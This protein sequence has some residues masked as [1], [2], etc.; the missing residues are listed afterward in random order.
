MN[1][2]TWWRRKKNICNEKEVSI[3]ISKKAAAGVG[4]GASSAEKGPAMVR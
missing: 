1:C 2:R 3:M 4:V